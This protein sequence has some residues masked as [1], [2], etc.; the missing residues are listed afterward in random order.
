MNGIMFTQ[1]NFLLTIRRRKTNTRRLALLKNGIYIPKYKAGEKVYL[2]EPYRIEGMTVS[3][4]IV[5]YYPYVDETKDISNTCVD[6]VCKVLKQQE[7]S[8]SGFCNK[9][10]MPEWTANYYVIMTS[11]ELQQLQDIS[12]EDCIAE[13]IIKDT[14]IIDGS[15]IYGMPIMIAEQRVYAMTWYDSPREAY[16]AE[17]NMIHGKGT[18]E[19]NPYVFSYHYELFREE[20]E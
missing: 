20:K 6:R 8:K 19:S 17:I 16:A 18:W 9:M 11:V 13:G 12:D 7:T 2:K 5:L 10:F 4:L 1:P 14:S 3:G 15:V